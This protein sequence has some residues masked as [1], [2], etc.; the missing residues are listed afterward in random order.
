MVPPYRLDFTD[1]NLQTL[2]TNLSAS[3]SDGEFDTGVRSIGYMQAGRRA[4]AVSADHVL[5]SAEIFERIA[6]RPAL[7]SVYQTFAGES[8][9]WLPTSGTSTQNLLRQFD[10]MVSAWQAAH[11]AEDP[12]G[13]AMLRRIYDWVSDPLEWGMRVDSSAP[14]LSIEQLA[15]QRRGD[16]SEFAKLFFML[17]RRAGYNPTLNW[18]ARDMNGDEATHIVVGVDVGG[19]AHLL[20]PVYQSFNAPHQSVTRMS[21]RELLAWHWNNRAQDIEASSPRRAI[22][23]YTRALSIDPANPHFLTNRGTV[24]LREGDTVLAQAD[25]RSAI[26]AVSNFHPAIFELGNIE[27]DAGNYR[28]AATYYRRSVALAPSRID[29]RRNLVLAFYYAGQASLAQRELAALLLRDPSQ[30]ELA[31]LVGSSSS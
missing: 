6:H 12:Q 25:F 21:P 23:L 2:Y 27:Y 10:A 24:R 30:R 13:A 26:A 17:L 14:E 5:S 28:A 9:P 7:D 22:G 20:D 31:R 18:V 11:P 29:Y 19:Q 15:D 4:I 8:L 3:V 1:S 16:C